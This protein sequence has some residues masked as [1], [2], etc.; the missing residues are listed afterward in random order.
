MIDDFRGRHDALPGIDSD[1][2]GESVRPKPSRGIR[3]NW[4][5]YARIVSYFN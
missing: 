1:K 3:R 5:Q 4:L 2:C